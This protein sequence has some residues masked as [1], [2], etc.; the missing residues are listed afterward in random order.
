MAEQDEIHDSPVGWVHKDI[1]EYVA[2]DGDSGNKSPGTPTLLLT[3]RG[4]KSGLKRRTALI[5]GTDGGNYVVVASNGGSAHHP[6]WY[7]NLVQT[8]EVELQVGAEKFTA[9]AHTAA[10]EEKTRL[11]PIMT[12]IFPMY[13]KFQASTERDIP[14]VVFV[15]AP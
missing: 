9:V 7:L 10:P 1:Q 6:T 15:P 11:W 13:A 3:T 4:R 5:Y 2:T 14:V 12:A 8:P